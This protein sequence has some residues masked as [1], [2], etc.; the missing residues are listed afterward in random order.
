LADS[1]NQLRRGQLDPGV[2]NSIGYLSSVQLRSF[3]QGVLQDHIAKLEESLGLVEMSPIAHPGK[4]KEVMGS[5]QSRVERARREFD[6]KV[7][8]RMTRILEN[9]SDDEL[10]SLAATGEW[11]ETDPPPG[12]SRLDNMDRRDLL[13]LWKKCKE[14]FEGRGR[15]QMEF[16]TRNRHWPEQSCGAQCKIP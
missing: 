5:I 12:S 1:I 16:F 15:E 14:R 13:E 2:A 6:F 3:E 8:I 7:W 10:E 4:G 9:M 11:P